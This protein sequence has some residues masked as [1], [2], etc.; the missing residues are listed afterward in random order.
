MLANYFW[1][2][3]LAKALF[4]ALHAVEVALRNTVHTTLTNR[5]RTQEW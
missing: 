5:Y 2:M 4:P 3:D 1:N